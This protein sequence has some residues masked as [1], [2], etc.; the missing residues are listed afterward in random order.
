MKVAQELRGGNVIMIS[1][2]PWVVVKAE[3]NKSGRNAAVM[4]L[5]LR[6]LLKGT[7]TETVVKADEKYED[8][9]L[10]KK[11]VTYSYFSE[12]NYVFMDSEYNQH[13][14]DAETLGDAVHYLDE[15]MACEMTFYEG[16]GISIELPNSVIREIEYTEPAVRGDTSGKVMKTARMIGGLEIKV[17]AFCEIGEKIEIDT[18]TGEY[19]NRAK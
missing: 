19:K 9:V 12:P 17:P 14:V 4:K 8:I 16:R 15:G 1:A 5:K 10:D 13:E 3:F 2:E 11:E 18:R 6:S 7:M